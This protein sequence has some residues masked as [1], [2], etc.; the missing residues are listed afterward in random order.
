MGR[1]WMR[2]RPSAFVLD[3]TVFLAQAFRFSL[4]L[5]LSQ[6]PAVVRQVLD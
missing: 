5:F 2:A 6:P 4:S 1:S 3:Y